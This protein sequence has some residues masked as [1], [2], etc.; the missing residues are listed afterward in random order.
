MTLAH[1]IHRLAPASP[2]SRRAVA[3]AIALVLTLAGS[4]AGAQ[5][6]IWTDDDWADGN[7]ALAEDVNPEIE[8]GM[9][10]LEDDLSDMRYLSTPTTW[11]GIYCLHA[12]RDTLYLAT[13]HQPYEIDGAEVLAYD[14]LT[15]TVSSAYEPY[16]EGLLL[17]KQFG[18]TMWIPGPDYQG[19]W[20]DPGRLYGYNGDEWFEQAA[21][22]SSIHVNDVE[23]VNGIMYTTAG[24]KDGLARTWVSFDMGETCT[25]ALSM[26][27]SPDS[28][29]RRFFGAGQFNGRVYIQPDGYP[30]EGR[31]LYSSAD[32]VNWDTLAVEGMPVDKMAT[33]V[34]LGDSLFMAI[35]HK[36]FIYDGEEWSWYYLPFNAWRWCRGYHV[37]EGN[38]YGG[39]SSCRLFRWL[40][41]PDWEEVA[42]LPA[43]AATEEIESIVT[44][45]GRLYVSTSRPD[46][47]LDGKLYVSAAKSYGRLLSQVHDFGY[48]TQDALLEFDHFAAYAG[49]PVRFQVRSAASAAEIESRAFVGPD[50]T[51]GTYYVASGTELSAVHDGDRYFQYSAE[52]F[53]P[54]QMRAPMLYSVTLAADSLAGGM[55]LAPA[56]D[57]IAA[58]SGALRVTSPQ[59]TLGSRGVDFEVRLQAPDPAASRATRLCIFDAQGR[60]I[61]S[62]PLRNESG[63]SFAWHWDL[64]DDQGRRVPSGVYS[65]ILDGSPVGE[66]EAVRPVVLIR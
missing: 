32:G 22:D 34:D 43:D 46:S 19:L 45:H 38:F 61:R 58:L 62:A 7:Y 3:T 53:C 18:D 11:Q 50:G 2:C 59:P 51:V 4:L 21:M 66:G 55:D 30:P 5:S 48:P 28:W 10:V 8:P 9:L 14:Y 54:D 52:L 65:A 27:H 29:T 63:P 16:E 41:G 23:V 6:L 33:F 49:S 42:V 57:P 17:I 1:W 44:Y 64:R 56:E 20:I 25:A 13:S 36:Y 12:Y 60:L 24:Q 37:R 26:D 31:V 35:N 15:D 39:G 40:G 47:T